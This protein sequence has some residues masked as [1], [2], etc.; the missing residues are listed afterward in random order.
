M[1]VLVNYV[2]QDAREHLHHSEIIEI[3]SPPYS[4]T[5]DPPVYKVIKWKEKKQ[6]TLPEGQKIVIMSM[7]KI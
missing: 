3:S 7:Y 5:S 2:V 1:K 6:N 4:F